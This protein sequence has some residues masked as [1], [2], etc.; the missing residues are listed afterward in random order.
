MTQA[1]RTF[2][3]FVSSTFADL[4]EE[5]NALQR[6]VFPKLRQLCMEHGARFQVVDLRWGVRDEAGLDQRTMAICLDEIRRCRET[7]PRPNFL[8]LLGDRYGWQPVPAEI[9]A[10]ELEEIARRVSDPEHR[11]LLQQWYRRDDNAV[12]PAYCLRPR[13]AELAA[14]ADYA[15]WESVERTLRAI[16]LR[17]TADMPLSDPERLEYGAS[18]TEQEIAHGALRSDDAREHVFCFFRAIRGL[19]RDGSAG[20]FLDPDA[21]AGARL[22]RL[23]DTLRSRLPGNVHDYQ[24]AWTG[25]GITTDHVAQL[26]DDVRERLSRV[27]LDEIRRLEQVDALDKEID[28]HR[29]FARDRARHFVGRARPLGAIAAYAAASPR[30]P[31]VVHGASGSGKS[32]LLACALE[33]IQAETV[34]RFIGATPGSSDVRTL[35]ETLCRE[36]S[37]RHGA[38]E[39]TV[40]SDYKDLVE[41]LPKRLALATAQRPLVVVLDAVD[42]LSDADRA[43]SLQWL[44]AELPEHARVVVSTLP[45]EC[46]T[47]LERKL[48]AAALVELEPMSPGEGSELLDL[49]LAGAG[50]R[51][52]DA[53]RAEVL[54]K[55]A[56][57]GLPLYLKLAFEEARSWRSY[58][59]VPS[60]P[61]D[62]PGLIRHLFARLSSDAN[63]GAMLVSR[64]LAYLAAA[65]HGL[66]EGELIDVLSADD[67]VFR[68]FMARARHEPP[69]KR[70]PVVVWSRLYFDLEP[71]LTERSGDGTALLA[72]Y[73]RQLLE[74]ATADYLVGDTGRARHAQLAR[75]FAG[76]Q[77][78]EQQAPNLRKLSELPFQQTEGELWESLHGTLTDFDFLQAKCTHVAVSGSD[79]RR[80]YGGVYELQEDYRRALERFPR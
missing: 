54:G 55:F 46:L 10:A 60:L 1:T 13:T 6:D 12:P 75:Y 43:R 62:V 38:D 16:L 71:Y 7:S 37:R 25:R 78:F 70:L 42:Q 19:P 14:F 52:G 58:D 21:D 47:A 30:H 49:W 35:L 18:A 32:A 41:E 39:A 57:N 67:E 79:D 15:A 29:R 26:C 48:P 44:P 76:Q 4:T 61:H 66:T 27:I 36:V 9:S 65:R 31:L 68:D 17:A 59:R 28:D 50:R 20:A 69:E 8:V 56:A 80:V 64:S 53:Q 74:V 73:H 40:P 72:F 11:A 2:R 51:L 34:V 63:H 45:G 3:I 24:A 33:S 5:R 77:L 23:K 22:D